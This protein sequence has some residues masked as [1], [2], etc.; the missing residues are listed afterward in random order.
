MILNSPLFSDIEARLLFKIRTGHIEC[1]SNFKHMY[2]DKSTK[3]SI[4]QKHEDDQKHI[5]ECINIRAKLR[6]TGILR[7]NILYEDIY[8]DNIQKQKAITVVYKEC[9]E[10]RGTLI[11]NLLDTQD[12]STLMSAGG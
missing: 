2:K 12:L 1:K 5:V 11:K 10:I 8:S 9:L 7:E 3:C 6:S 4:C